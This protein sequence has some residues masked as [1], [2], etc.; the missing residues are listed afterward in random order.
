[1]LTVKVSGVHTVGCSTYLL[2]SKGLCITPNCYTLCF[3]QGISVIALYE[4]DTGPIAYSPEL[5]EA[6]GRNRNSFRWHRRVRHSQ[7][8]WMAVLAATARELRRDTASWVQW[9]SV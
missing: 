9:T 8:H 2:A 3:N 7:A 5:G 4:P 6:A 1:M